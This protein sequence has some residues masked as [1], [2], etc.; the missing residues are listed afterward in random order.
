MSDSHPSSSGPPRLVQILRLW[1]GVTQR[2]DQRSYAVTGFGL[3]L[4]KYAV[5]AAICQITT[6]QLFT[7]LDFLNPTVSGRRALLGVGH[8][9]IGWFMFLWSLPFLWIAVSMSVRRAIDAGRSPWTGLLVLIPIINLIVMISLCFMASAAN[10][11]DSLDT[12]YVDGHRRGMNAAIAVGV[13]IMVGALVLLVSVYVFSTYGASLFLGGPMLMGTTAS[14]LYNRGE[15][16]SYLA[17][18]G[19]GFASVFFAMCAL[20]LFALEGGICIAMAAPLVLPIGAMGGLVGK[21]MADATRPSGE[22]M[23]AVVVLPLLTGLE[24]LAARSPEYV[25]VTSVDVD[26][27][28]ESVWNHVVQFPELSEAKE[29]YFRLGIAC[30]KRATITGLGVGAVRRCEF[31]TG[32]FVEPITTWDA[33]RRLAF[34]VTQ[35]PD[36]MIELSPYRNVRP[37]HLNHFLRSTRGEFQLVP[38]NDG[39]TRLEGRTWY[40]FDMFPASYWSLWS[41]FFIHRIHERVLEHIKGLAEAKPLDT[42]S[43]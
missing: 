6:G 15:K 38:L 28:V 22:W 40:R 19:V 13:S 2:V 11:I 14:Y 23:A 12:G 10:T 1:F 32:T 16:R 31:T 29:W 5:E 30:P 21:A 33:P 24:S 25:V 26:A 39:R 9:W 42:S 34:D 8:E 43:K 3:M 7:P 18:L 41:D 36:P 27:S 37:P 20:L 17:S 35:Q 4:V